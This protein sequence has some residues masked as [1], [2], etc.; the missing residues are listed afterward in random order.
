MFHMSIPAVQMS[1][2][3]VRNQEVESPKTV[4]TVV[5]FDMFCPE[6]WGFITYAGPWLQHPLI[7]GE[8]WRVAVLTQPVQKFPDK[9]DPISL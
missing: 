1:H 2:R 7:L 8:K 6:P 3:I 4:Q 5:V 9:R